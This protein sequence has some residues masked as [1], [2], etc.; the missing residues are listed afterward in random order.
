MLTYS[1]TQART[2]SAL[3]AL[4]DLSVKE[5][6]L[7]QVEGGE[8]KGE[9]TVALEL[10]QVGDVLKVKRGS[11][12]PSDGEIVFGAGS[13]DESMVTGESVP[14]RKTVGEQVIGGTINEVSETR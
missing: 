6:T 1:L 5:A 3:A 10:V 2:S 12:V 4:A 14:L 9:Q 13:L 11:Q 7:L 8:V